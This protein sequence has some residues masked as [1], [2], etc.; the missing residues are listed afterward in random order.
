[1]LLSIM[2]LL[3]GCIFGVPVAIIAG[4]FSEMISKQAGED[5]NKVD[6]VVEQ[7]RLLNEE[8]KEEFK[9]KI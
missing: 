2:T 9:N 5:E 1:M 8:E 7:Y 3:G 6:K 4:G